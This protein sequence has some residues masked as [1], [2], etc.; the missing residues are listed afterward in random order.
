M[1][2]DLVLHQLDMLKHQAQIL[3]AQIDALTAITV[4]VLP[5]P[6]PEPAP[7]T[8]AQEAGPCQHPVEVRVPAPGMGNPNRFYCGACRKTAGTG[9]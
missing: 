8:V 7:A 5:E 3:L 2:R 1:T 4:Q 6:T 9:L